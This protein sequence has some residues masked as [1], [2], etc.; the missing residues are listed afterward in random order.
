M[1]VLGFDNF[2]RLRK[3][4]KTEKTYELLDMVEYRQ[5]YYAVL[6]PEGDSQNEVELFQILATDDLNETY[7]P[8]EDEKTA[9]AVFDIFLERNRE[10][11]AV[12][13]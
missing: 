12:E 9:K 2:L 7:A 11:F 3:K 10:R 13:E 8:V 5:G 1:G 4:D 6:L